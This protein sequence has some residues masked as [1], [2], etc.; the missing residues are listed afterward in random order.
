M[1]SFTY[2]GGGETNLTLSPSVL[3]FHNKPFMAKRDDFGLTFISFIYSY[4]F[5]LLFLFFGVFM[6]L[7]R[8]SIV[9]QAS[10]LR[11]VDFTPLSRTE[12]CQVAT[13]Q[14]L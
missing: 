9:L 12:S 3:D 6:F 11:I 7:F 4:H 1:L 14:P 2:L 13:T 10:F 8:F 5:D